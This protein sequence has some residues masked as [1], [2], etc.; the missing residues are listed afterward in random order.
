MK[1]KASYRAIKRNVKRFYKYPSYRSRFYFA[2][3]YGNLEIDEKSIFFESYSGNNFSGNVYNLFLDIIKQDEFKDFKKIIGIKK[4][5][6]EN[7]KLFLKSKN[8]DDYQ[9]VVVDSKDYCKALITSRYIFNNSTLPVYFIKNQKQTMVNTWHGTPLKTLGRSVIG[10]AHEIGNTQRNF[11]MS[12]YLVF[13]NEFTYQCLKKDFMLDNIF[14]GKYLLNGYPRNHVFYNQDAAKQLKKYLDLENTEVICYMP[15][16]RGAVDA[17]QN[18]KLIEELKEYLRCIDESLNPHKLLFVNLHNFVKEQIDLSEYQYIKP[19]PR[20]VET[21]EFL[22]ISDCLITDYSSVFFDYANLD[23]KIILFAYDKEEY[24]SSRGLYFP[25]EKLPFPIV[26]TAKDVVKELENLDSFERYDNFKKEFCPW[27]KNETSKNIIDYV[28]FNKC[29]DDLKI[30]DGHDFKNTK[31]NVLIYAGSLAKNGITSSLKGLINHIDP[32]KYNFT[33]LFYRSAVRRHTH[34]IEQFPHKI[35]YIPIQ[36]K[37][38]ITIKESFV[39]FLYYRMNSHPKWIEKSLKEMYRREVLRIFPNQNFDYAIHFSG[40]EKQIV[41]LINALKE[42]KKIIFVHSNMKKEMETR[43]NFH[44][45]SV[46]KA[47]MEYDKIAGVRDGIDKELLELLP[48]DKEK[49]TTVHNVNNIDQIIEKAL[50]PIAFDEGTDSTHT[51]EEIEEILAKKEVLKFINVARFSPE[52][53]IMRLIKAFEVYLENHDGYLFVIGG[54]GNKYR[55]ILDY[56]TENNL[57][58]VIIIRSLSN[59]F[60]ILNQCDNF[61]L[62]SLYEGL[63]I[64]IMEALILNK[65]VI[66]TDI[67]GPK[68]FLEKGYGYIVE[69]SIEGLTRG[70]VD[71][72]DHK[73]K[74]VKFDPYAFNEQALKEFYEL[75]D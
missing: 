53:G 10:S 20:F 29:H 25:M 26:K 9:I 41:H 21:Y 23:K 4:N 45:P 34:E 13:P 31:K 16:W 15:T 1:I 19:F 3:Y 52:K 49:I 57:D 22:A 68:P 61:I 58:K 46:F 51:I 43:S 6:V 39:Q 37:R 54:H 40:Y 2:K 74:L 64:S 18:L 17:K 56:V 62:S 5:N 60:S 72:Y 7:L 55:E 24:L 38:D 63:P 11:M 44:L 65:P 47:Y 30:I 71:A 67:E 66:C 73:I 48:L 59:P 8:I 36:G 28:F 75:F 27:D 35:N 33:L 50:L 12:D 42:T 69:N 70:M 14:N 32:D